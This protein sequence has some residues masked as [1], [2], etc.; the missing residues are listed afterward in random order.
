MSG[1]NAFLFVSFRPLGCAVLSIA[2]LGVSG[3]TGPG[4]GP[5][6]SLGAR[7]I[8][9]ARGASHGCPLGAAPVAVVNSRA[10]VLASE[11][12]PALVER[13]AL[14]VEVV[15]IET[16]A[17]QTRLDA[18]DL[19]DAVTLAEID[20]LILNAERVEN[21]L[22]SALDERNRRALAD[23]TTRL[24]SHWTA[25]QTRRAHEIRTG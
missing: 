11:N 9:S 19:V 10:P 7:P 25:F 1:S 17:L 21:M 8:E 14:L 13:A 15:R 3:C 4:I 12:D 18:Q 5:G 23:A 24:R 20:R 6:S 2:L 16:A 22:R